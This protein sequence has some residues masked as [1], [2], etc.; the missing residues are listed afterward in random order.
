[1]AIRPED[2]E[3]FDEQE[4]QCNRQ[5]KQFKWEMMDDVKIEQL[6]R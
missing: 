2:L 6:D 3:V 5:R 1:M 4:E